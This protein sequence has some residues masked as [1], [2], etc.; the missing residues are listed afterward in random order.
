MALK[1]CEKVLNNV[2]ITHFSENYKIAQRLGSAPQIPMYTLLTQCRVQNIAK[3]GAETKLESNKTTA[4][5]EIRS[6]QLF[7]SAA[8]KPYFY[9]TVKISRR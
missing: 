2:K 3:G 4:L 5:I 6:A 8:Y 1:T 9:D 7:S